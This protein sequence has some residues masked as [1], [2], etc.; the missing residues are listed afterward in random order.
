MDYRAEMARNLANAQQQ[1]IGA[2]RDLAAMIAERNGYIQSWHAD[3]ADKLTDALSKLSDARESLEQGPVAPPARRIARRAGRHGAVGR[4]GVGR[5]GAD[6]RPAIHHPG[7]DRRAAGGRSQHRRQATTATCMSAIRSRSSSTPSRTRNTAW[8]TAWCASSARTAS[9][10]RTSSAIRP[11][12]SRCRARQAP[13]V[14]F[15]RARITLDRIDLHGTPAGFHLVPGMPVTAD[16]RVGKRTVLRY[17]LG[18]TVPLA[19]EAMREP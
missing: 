5:L 18:R 16:I 13:S 1:A 9:P 3:I 11:A 12:R 7:A 17:M 19:T 15:Y 10:R 8:P 4:Q 14:V 6:S 2:Q